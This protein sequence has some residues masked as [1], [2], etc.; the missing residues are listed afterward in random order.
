MCSGYQLDA[1]LGIKVEN[2]DFLLVNCDIL[3]RVL[4]ANF[5]VFHILS[6]IHI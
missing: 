4:I 2:Y 5:R 1:V 3:N 6:L